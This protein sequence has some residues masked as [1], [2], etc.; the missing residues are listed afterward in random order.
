MEDLTVVCWQRRRGIG[1]FCYPR[2]THTASWIIGRIIAR[3]AC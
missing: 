1:L 3:E 2:E